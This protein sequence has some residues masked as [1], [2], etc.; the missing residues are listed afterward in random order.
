MFNGCFVLMWVFFLML[1]WVSVI[2]SSL[3]FHLT[4]SQYL[5]FFLS[6]LRLQEMSCF[7]NKVY[8][9]FDSVV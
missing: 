3:L 2:F 4:V 5:L 1:S 7:D 9:K 8:L 6:S